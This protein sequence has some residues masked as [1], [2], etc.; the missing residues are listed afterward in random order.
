LS[1]LSSYAN[2]KAMNITPFRVAVDFSGR[3]ES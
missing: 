3:G 1:R 2:R